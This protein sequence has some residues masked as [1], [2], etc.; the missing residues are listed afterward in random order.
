MD[1]PTDSMVDLSI[2]SCKCLP[3]G[4]QTDLLSELD[5]DHQPSSF[6]SQHLPRQLPPSGLAE[7]LA[8][9][10]AVA[11]A[12][13][14]PFECLWFEDAAIPMLCDTAEAEDHPN[15]LICY[16]MLMFIVYSF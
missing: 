3:E 4:K 16:D 1:L 5:P 12:Q 8:Q 7:G 2:V 15:G 14:E 9:R 13:V 11:V 6:P 10:H